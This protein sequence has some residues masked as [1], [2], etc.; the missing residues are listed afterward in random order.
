MS[1]EPVEKLGS[2][3]RR[4]RLEELDDARLNFGHE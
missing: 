4:K 2:L 1:R 3:I